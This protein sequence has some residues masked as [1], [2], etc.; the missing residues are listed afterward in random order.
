MTEDKKV[1]NSNETMEDAMNSFQEVNVGD[2]VKGE[3][4]AVEDKQVIVGI[5]GAGVEG[6]VPAKELS[7]T[8]VEDINE[9]VKV[10]DILDLVVITTIGKDK[11]NGS[12][13]LSK[14]RLDAKKSGKRSNKISKQVKS[15][16]HPL[17]TL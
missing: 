6:V 15:S 16:K 11:E 9:L 7:T 13:L 5:E 3:V 1:E 2:I 12:Y 8:Q 4:L 10:G 17:Q 14:R